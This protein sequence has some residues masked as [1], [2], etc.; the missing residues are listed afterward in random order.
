M[1]I[2]E[3]ACQ[4]DIY[5][6]QND[7]SRLE[8]NIND[9]TTKVEFILKKMGYEKKWIMKERYSYPEKIHTFDSREELD[10]FLQKEKKKKKKTFSIYNYSFYEDFILE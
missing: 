10:A 3:V 6:L 4:S 1:D 7:I 5:D 9:L 2:S 8:N